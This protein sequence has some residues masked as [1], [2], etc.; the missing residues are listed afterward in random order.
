VHSS[1]SNSKTP[2]AWPEHYWQRPIPTAHWR[3]VSLLAALLLLGYIVA[4]ETWWRLQDYE[5]TYSETAE[6]WARLRDRAGTGRADEVVTTGSSRI[7][8][9]F[10]LDVW[11]QDFG[12]PKPISLPR[13]GTNPRPFLHD[14]AQDPNFRGL[15]LVGITE[16]LFFAPDQAPPA[17]E[18]H[19]YLKHRAER[20]VSARTDWL[21]AIPFRGAFASLNAED[22]SLSPLIRTRLLTL[23]NRE[24][25]RVPPALPPYFAQIDKDRR[26]HMWSSME[27]DPAFQEKV[28]QVWLPLFQLGPPFGG[29]GLDALF[30]SV[31]ADVDAIR[32]RGGQVVFLR[33]P[34]SGGVL[35]LEKARWPREQYWDRLLKETGAPGVH[36]E[37]HASLSGFECPEWSHLTRA[38]AV[39]YTRN[40]IPILKRE[41]V[42]Q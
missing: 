35:E 20:P 3:G 34:S 7:Q 15:L 38:D 26:H 37:D 33:F 42:R 30:A 5:S 14:L 22:L 12:G 25:A 39:T 11:L 8:F 16:G 17:A 29:P 40:L 31:K 9:D 36:F 21:L 41:I 6:H 24:G 27:Q 19:A 10:D 13:V 32:A 2:Q 28:R 1:T 18:A 23:P 4:W